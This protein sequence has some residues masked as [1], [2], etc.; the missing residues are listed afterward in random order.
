MR[1]LA[2]LVPALALGACGTSKKEN[3]PPAAKP[4][5]TPAAPAVTTT[6]PG[7]GEAEEFL[8][9]WLAQV[10]QPYAAQTLAPSA[11]VDINGCT[12]GA[13]CLPRLKDLAG[14]TLATS[15]TEMKMTKMKDRTHVALVADDL[16]VGTLEI[17]LAQHADQKIMVE[18]VRASW[19]EPPAPTM[20]A[21]TAFVK[22]WLLSMRD[23]APAADLGLDDV[24]VHTLHEVM[25][26]HPTLSF[27]VA[28][29]NKDVSGTVLARPNAA[30]VF[31]EAIG[32]GL[33]K[34]GLETANI[35]ATVVTAPDGELRIVEVRVASTSARKTGT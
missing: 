27:S 7:G 13:S 18:S 1:I 29:E 31:V 11:K 25:S 30:Y 26:A 16:L 3:P 34:S 14:V 15:F 4:V 17:E 5:E 20:D 10:D 23:N 32:G 6:P 2:L 28:V 22:Q 21:A 9:A 33:Q 35:S 19:K 8:E 12:A 24:S